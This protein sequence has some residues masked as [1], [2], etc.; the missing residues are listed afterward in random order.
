MLVAVVLVSSIRMKDM[1][2]FSLVGS[3]TIAR[4][5]VGPS[6]IVAPW[7]G[8]LIASSFSMSADDGRDPSGRRIHGIPWTRRWVKPLLGM[9]WKLLSN[10]LRMTLRY[11]RTFSI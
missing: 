11:F 6:M 9:S 2:P 5:H 8:T 1:A 3:V 7:K 10:D 4:L